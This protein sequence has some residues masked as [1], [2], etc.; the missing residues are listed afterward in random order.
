[1]TLDRSLPGPGLAD[2]RVIAATPE[3]AR[4]VAELLRHWFTGGEQRSYPAGTSG[5]GTRL[6]LTVD[7]TQVAEQW[8]SEQLWPATGGEA[9]P[10][11][12]LSADETS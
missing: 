11:L 7:V 4:Q 8:F 10:G 2:V 5:T 1:M 6:N 12:A 9:P 3:V